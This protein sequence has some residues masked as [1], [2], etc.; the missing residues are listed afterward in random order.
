MCAGLSH[1]SEITLLLSPMYSE[2][3]DG[4]LTS[5]MGTITIL[6][7]PEWSRGSDETTRVKVPCEPEKLFAAAGDPVP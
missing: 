1:V 3:R 7:D 5:K 4:N 2:R 6:L